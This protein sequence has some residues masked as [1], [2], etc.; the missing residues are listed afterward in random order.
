MSI[1]LVING[2]TFEYPV[3]FDENWGVDATGWAQAVTNG[4]LQRAGGNFPLLAEV[5]FGASFGLKAL[6]LKSREANPAH[7]GILRLAN[8][9]S[10]LVWRNGLNNGDL[11]LTTDSSNNL[12]FNGVPIGSAN[13]LTDSHIF[14]GN[15]SNVPTDVAMSGDVHISNAGATTIQPGAVTSSKIATGTVTDGNMLAGTLTDTSINAAANIALSKLAPLTANK[16]LQSDAFGVVAA[17]SVTSTELGF[18]AGAS[19]NIQAQINAITGSGSFVSG[20]LLAYAGA[21]A[22]AGWLMCDGAAVS[23]STYSSLFGVVGVIYGPGDGSTT[24]NLPNM[25]NNVAVGQ[26]GSIAPS[27]GSTS[28]A[29]TH[30]LSVSEIPA[31]LTVTDPGHSHSVTGAPVGINAAGGGNG[32]F[33]DT[34]SG[35]YG[36]TT[37]TT[38]ISVGGGG[39]A[40]SIVQPSL[41]INFIIK[42]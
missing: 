9:S 39:A 32:P 28:G 31:G 22:P 25:V 6:Y 23:R 41:G 11:A 13:T 24:F 8:A 18:V 14:V 21:S 29:T 19:S 26:G 35:S 16:A 15:V 3:D 4:M 7:T 20:M 34:A 27:L 5:D 12:L 33:L 40:H 17:S 37:N 30:T 38:G 36:T 1:P 10:G 2:A 42:T